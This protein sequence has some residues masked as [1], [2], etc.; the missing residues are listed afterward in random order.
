MTIVEELV[1]ALKGAVGALEFSRDYHA[2]LGNEDQAF[3]QD[4]L[5]AATKAIARFEDD[6][7]AAYPSWFGGHYAGHGCAARS[8]PESCD[9]PFCA[10]DSSAGRVLDAINEQGL[11]VVPQT[12]TAKMIAAAGGEVV[13][14]ER[15]DD[16]SYSPADVWGAM[17]E[18]A[19]RP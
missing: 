9:W 7:I 18:A 2:D 10:C 6:A 17:L 3:A 4:R 5:D 19:G 12:P 8:N 16:P 15:A 11:V 1:A 14:L 13:N